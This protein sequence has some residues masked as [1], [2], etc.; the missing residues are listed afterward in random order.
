MDELFIFVIVL[1]CFIITLAYGL[2]GVVYLVELYPKMLGL[3]VLVYGVCEGIL[4]SYLMTQYANIT[5]RGI[6]HE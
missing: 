5:R 1:L 6:N 4:F 3:V 2:I